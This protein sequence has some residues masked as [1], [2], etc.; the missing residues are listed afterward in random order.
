MRPIQLQLRSYMDKFDRIFE[1]HAIL[2]AR[3][4]VIPMEDLTAR[5]ECNRAT[6]FRAISTLKD[7]LHAPI[8]FDRN[9]G[10]YRY[11]PTEQGITYELPGLWFTPAELQALIVLQRLIGSRER[12]VLEEHFAP[13]AKRLDELTRHRRLQLTEA[14]AR[15]R[16]PA[17]A[18]RP[19]G[20][21]FQVAATATLQRR[22][23]WMEYHARSSDEYSERTV[24]P[25]RITHY[26][27]S[28]YVGSVDTYFTRC[29]ASPI[30]CC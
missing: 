22:K 29:V 26:R 6:V 3:R 8:V 25:Q 30:V 17:L 7:R 5:L 27:E 23:L 2:A 4:T 16:L 9:A 13:L 18:A 21:A 19:S 20:P 15:I 12:G 11:A 24:S 28:W 1:L 10:G 14:T